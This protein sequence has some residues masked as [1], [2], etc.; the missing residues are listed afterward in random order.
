MGHGWF[1]EVQDEV[2]Y[3]K[4]ELRFKFKNRNENIRNIANISVV[5]SNKFEHPHLLEEE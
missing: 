1:E 5:T 4:Q 3:D 2:I